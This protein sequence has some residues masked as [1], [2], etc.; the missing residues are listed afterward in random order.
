MGPS[1]VQTMPITTCRA[2]S[3]AAGRV[4]RYADQHA[5]TH[6]DHGTEPTARRRELRR[7]GLRGIGSGT[8]YAAFLRCRHWRVGDRMVFEAAQ[9]GGRY[10]ALAL[11]GGL[12]LICVACGGGSSS[13]TTTQQ[14]PSAV[15]PAGSYSVNV[16]GTST[17][18]EAAHRHVVHD[19]RR[20]FGK[21]RL[22]E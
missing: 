3:T 8:L 17:R 2:P 11:L 13:K 16:T 18:R 1:G 21:R 15:T 14:Q 9:E 5:D 19:H 4:P 22:A 20:I 12:M 6:T 7:P 10:A